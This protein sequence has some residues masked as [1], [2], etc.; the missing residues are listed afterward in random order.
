MR[1]GKMG[2]WM[3]R[4]VLGG[5]LL[6]AA[7]AVVAKNEYWENNH[8]L[9]ENREAARA[10]FMP[11]G[12]RVGDRQLSLNG[13]WK[14][15]WTKTPEGRVKDFWHIDFD[16]SEWNT[17]DVP[18]NWEVNGYGT[19]IYAS[20]GY[21]FKI[22]PPYVTKEPKKKYTA[23]EER[24][25]TGQYKRQFTMP[26]SWQDGQVFL[27]FEG[28]MSAFFVW[29]NGQYV[30]Y[31]QGSMEPSVFN[32]TPYVRSGDNQIAVEV[33]KYSDGSYLE[34]QDFWR[35][36]GIHRDVTLYYTPNVRIRDYAIRTLPLQGSEGK[37]TA[38][39]SLQVSPQFAVYEG[40]TG[41]GDTLIAMLTDHDGQWWC[42]RG[43][44]ARP[45][46]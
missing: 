23:Y 22:E 28:V 42:Q 34:D 16:V 13:T 10:S 37:G 26:A 12:E 24:N 14:F 3:R 35:F 38:S 25:P 40:E 4:S 7:L 21:T 6:W 27:R 15:R 29:I 8:V 44:S 17:L 41:V 31:S 9:Q 18:A 20:A 39:Y 11:F 46:P 30:G 1:T 19:P 2:Y 36:G 43:R 5:V 33:Y 45:G 32:V